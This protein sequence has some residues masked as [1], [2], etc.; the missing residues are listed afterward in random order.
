MAREGLL[1]IKERPIFTKVHNTPPTKYGEVAEVYDSMIADGCV[2]EGR[3]ENSILFRGVRV[4]KGSVVRYSIL[5]S[6]TVVGKNASLDAVVT[7]KDVIVTEGRHL[8]GCEELPYFIPK[9][10]RL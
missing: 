3:V 2:V 4:E 9:K 6:G 10:K 8:S 5:L 1:G 7:D